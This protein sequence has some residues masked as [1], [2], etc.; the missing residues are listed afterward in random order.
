MNG[1]YRFN[2]LLATLE[3]APLYSTIN[4]KSLRGHRIFDFC[5]KLTWFERSFRTTDFT[6]RSLPLNFSNLARSV[7]AA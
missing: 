4:F 6:A 3:N 5:R 2:G 1:A 7:L